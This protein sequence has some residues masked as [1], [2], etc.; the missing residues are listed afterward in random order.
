MRFIRG[1]GWEQLLFIRIDRS[2]SF[3]WPTLQFDA[4]CTWPCPT[5]SAPHHPVGG[6]MQKY[7]DV[8]QLRNLFC[9]LEVALL[10]WTTLSL[11]GG[12]GMWLTHCKFWDSTKCKQI[13]LAEMKIALI[14]VNPGTYMSALLAAW[15]AQLLSTQVQMS[16]TSSLCSMNSAHSQP[17]TEG[18]RSHL[19]AWSAPV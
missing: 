14:G 6:S 3:S 5:S 4:L 8:R 11:W 19:E 2:V 10:N 13:G 1:S 17:C 7:T 12:T 18:V 16:A 9:V 15:S